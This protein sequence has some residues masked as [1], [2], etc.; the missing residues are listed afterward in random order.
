MASEVHPVIEVTTEQ[1]TERGWS[2]E[3]R[4]RTGA[5]G[6]G[7]GESSHVVTLSWRDHDYWCGGK[8]APSRMLELVLEH[9][10]K[11]YHEALPAKFDASTARRWVRTIDRDLMTAA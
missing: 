5:D 3:V 4:I 11:N 8:L 10:V 9:L 7:A 6:D 2:Y 1:E